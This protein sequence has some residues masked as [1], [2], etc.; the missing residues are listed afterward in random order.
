MTTYSIHT[1]FSS[2][3]IF[4]FPYQVISKENTY[5]VPYLHKTLQNIFKTII[6]LKIINVPSVNNLKF[7]T[8]WVILAQLEISDFFLLIP[9]IHN[10]FSFCI[11]FQQILP[12][13]HPTFCFT[14]FFSVYLNACGS[15]NN[16]ISGK[17][18]D[19]QKSRQ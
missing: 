15:K 1:Y 2:D 18:R 5:P 10:V 13:S 12:T 14:T 16:F 11:F 9:N 17:I 19:L 3:F 7:V 8:V 4:C 6:L